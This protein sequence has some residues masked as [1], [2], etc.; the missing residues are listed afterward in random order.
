MALLSAQSTEPMV[1]AEVIVYGGTPAGVMAAVA[2]ARH[3]RSVALIERHNHVGGIISSGLVNTDIG[4]RKTVGGLADEFLK[5]AVQYYVDKYGPRSPQYLACKNGRKFEP[6]IA[7]LIFEQMLKEQSRIT[8]YKKHRY[9][10]VKL[11]GN[12]V[13]QLIVEDL[14]NKTLRT[15]SGDLFIDASYEGDLMAGA[16]VPYRVGRE[17]KQ[18]YDESLAG[19][20]VGPNRGQADKG[21]MAYNYRVSITSRTEER[22]LFPKP[23][24][25]DPEPWRARFGPRIKSGKMKGF[26]DFFIS[27]AGANDKHDANWGDLVGGSEG[28]PDGDWETRAKIEARHRDYFLSLLY[29]V[30]NDPELP[31]AFRAD[32]QKWGLP[33][34]E[35]VDNGHFPF[36]IYVREARRMVGRYVLRESDL[37]KNRQKPDGVCAGNYGIDCHAVQK[38]MVNGKWVIDRTSHISVKPY[39]IP[40]ACLTPRE[41]G[42]LLVPV[43]CSATHVAYCSLR[44]E[45]VYMMLGHASGDAAH[46]ALA[47]RMTV[48]EVDVQKLRDLLRKE[49][50]VLTAALTGGPEP[51]PKAKPKPETKT[52]TN[53]AIAS[54]KDEPGLPRVLFNRDSISIGYALFQL[55]KN[56]ADAFDCDA[57]QKQSTVI[58]LSIA[59]VRTW[60]GTA[61]RRNAFTLNFEGLARS[62]LSGAGTQ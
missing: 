9:H 30:Q 16:Q 31:E 50:A 45:P 57:E 48:Q 37:T 40:Y 11:D 44:M 43:C 60:S 22:V 23:E 8:V 10:A 7:E 49:G 27:K 15:F 1:K 2:A 24:H 4:D 39:D 61:S 42:N 35:F 26:G 56:L 3:G 14:A 38:V 28:Y 55:F 41:L 36:Q 34:G 13:T 54:I 58:E 47:E 17:G 33:K 18:E 5:R 46:L 52:P 6:H 25:Y 19:I 29:Y 12:R 59:T 21:V 62:P 51:Q 20:N 53:L 32:A